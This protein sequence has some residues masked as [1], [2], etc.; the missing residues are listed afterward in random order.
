MTATSPSNIN[1]SKHVYLI[2]DDDSMRKTIGNMLEFLDYQVHIF[3][4][5]LDFLESSINGAPAVIITDMRMP[6]MNG[7]EL[8]AELIKR[9]RQIPF[10]FISGQSTVPQT[11]SAMKQG[12]IDFLVKPF[13]RDQL[14]LAIVRGLEQDAT[15]MRSYIERASLEEGLKALAPRE[16]E[17]FELL[18]LGFNNAQ[19][20]EKLKISLSTTKQY[21]SEVMRKLNLRSLAQLLALK[22]PAA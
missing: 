8:Q 3:S 1:D 2:D 19:I 22:N 20:Q 18:A 21:K 13:D 12:A 17:V 10:I 11:I 6:D 9:G 4:S 5:A 15:N 16:R 14:L 7:V